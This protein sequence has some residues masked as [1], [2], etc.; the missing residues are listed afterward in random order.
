VTSWRLPV[1]TSVIDSKGLFFDNVLV[2]RQWH[3]LKYEGVFIKAYTSVAAAHSRIG[4][5]LT[6]YT[7]TR[8][9]HALGYQTPREMFAVLACGYWGSSPALLSSR[10]DRIPTGTTTQKISTGEEKVP[11]DFSVS[12]TRIG[13]LVTGGTL[14]THP[15][16]CPIDKQPP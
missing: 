4:A 10:V 13:G 8:P 2:E 16:S 7:D 9:H 11:R 12:A 15:V 3:G 6:F 1:S 5:W 14:L